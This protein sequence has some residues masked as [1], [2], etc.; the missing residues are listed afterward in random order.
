MTNTG[1]KLKPVLGRIV[2]YLQ[3]TILLTAVSALGVLMGE[4]GL[5]DKYQLEEKKLLLVKENERLATEIKSLEHSLS[6]LRSDS[7]TIEKVA[8][9][10]LGMAR[11]DETVYVFQGRRGSAPRAPDPEYGLDNDHNVP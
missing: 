7:R 5:T 11:P 6:M 9:R 4:K 8:K 3:L 10:K 1:Q 2:K